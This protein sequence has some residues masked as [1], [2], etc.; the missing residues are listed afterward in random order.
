MFYKVAVA[1]DAGATTTAFSTTGNGG[2]SFSM[3]LGAYRNVASLGANASQA[4]VLADTSTQYQTTY[5]LPSVSNTQP[6]LL[7]EFCL[8]FYGSTLGSINRTWT[9]VPDIVRV[10]VGGG[11]NVVGVLLTDYVVTVAGTTAATTAVNTDLGN[12]N[13]LKAGVG[14][15]VFLNDGGLYVPAVML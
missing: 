9:T 15:R 5:H 8:G 13:S 1:A 4:N 14:W 10:N 7:A 6:G 12:S 2:S 11:Y 3:V